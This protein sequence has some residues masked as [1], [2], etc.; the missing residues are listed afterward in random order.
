[1]APTRCRQPPEHHYHRSSEHDSAPHTQCLLHATYWVKP[2]LS[3]L[4]AADN[5]EVGPNKD[6]APSGP[7][8]VVVS[9]TAQQRVVAGLTLVT[10]AS[11][12]I[13]W[14][15]ASW[16]SKIAGRA[17]SPSAFNKTQ[18]AC[19]RMF[20]PCVSKVLFL[21][22]GLE[23]TNVVGCSVQTLFKGDKNQGGV[24][25]VNC[26][27]DSSLDEIPKSDPLRIKSF[28]SILKLLKCFQKLQ[29]MF[30]F[31]QNITTLNYKTRR[32]QPQCR[33]CSLTVT[34]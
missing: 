30:G 24:F 9:P 20:R 23:P 3:E 5:E 7:V 22:L 26:K 8:K 10:R 34:K 1:M 6:R 15:P 4:L 33:L 11:A 29:I 25:C 27:L 2:I 31:L 28:H 32:V 16:A 13:A 12:L 19:T 21:S 18:L 17:R 14:F